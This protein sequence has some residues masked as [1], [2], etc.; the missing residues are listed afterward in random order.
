MDAFDNGVV[1][2]SQSYGARSRIWRV[3]YVAGTGWYG[4]AAMLDS[5][6]AGN[7]VSPAV[8]MDALG[9]AIVVW[10]QATDTHHVMLASRFE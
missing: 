9:H 2:W 3:H 1:V 6:D 5:A 10:N 8:A 7:D 4:S